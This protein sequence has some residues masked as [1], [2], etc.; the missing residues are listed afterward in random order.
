VSATALASLAA[1]V[2]DDA[3]YFAIVDALASEAD[4]RAKQLAKLERRFQDDPKRYARA[5]DRAESAAVEIDTA[6]DDVTAGVPLT[7]DDEAELEG[8]HEELDDAYDG[9][10]DD[11][12]TEWEI[13]FEYRG[14]DR[15]KNVDVNIRIRREDGRAFGPDEAQRALYQ[16]Q[17][18]LAT[19]DANPVPRGYELA[20]IDWRRP[21]RSSG[22]TGG[23][24]DYTALTHFHAP[25]YTEKD[26]ASAWSIGPSFR[27]GSV[28]P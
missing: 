8:L 19:E 3:A 15:H 21:R 2:D 5:V 13:G 14:G 9:L 25:M 10:D 27:L 11:F 22:W 28:K 12:N 20:A 7:D 24:D 1:R 4:R 23:D 16:F 18:N 6:L 17:Q 26:N